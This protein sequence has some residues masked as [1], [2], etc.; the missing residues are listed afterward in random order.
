M[1]RD[2]TRV[3]KSH[4][5]H[6]RVTGG[7]PK[8]PRGPPKVTSGL[9]ES[10][11][12]SQ[13]SMEGHSRVPEGHSRDRRVPKGRRRANMSHVTGTRG[14]PNVTPGCTSHMRVIKVSPGDFQDFPGVLQRSRASLGDSWGPGF[15]WRVLSVPQCSQGIPGGFP[16]FS[17]FLGRCQECRGSLGEVLGGS[18][19]VFGVWGIPWG[20]RASPGDP[21]VG[22]ECPRVSPGDSRGVPG[23]LQHCRGSLEGPWGGS[24]GVSGAPGGPEGRGGPSAPRILQQ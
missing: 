1:E 17:S 10:H 16:G 8:V 3:H 13:R 4:E 5:G 9:H 7:S 12:V 18:W 23:V 15:S 2:H 20:S 22:P 21:R 19:E 14:S 24:R 11:G 6:T